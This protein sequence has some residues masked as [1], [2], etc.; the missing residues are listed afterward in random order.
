MT[1]NELPRRLLGAGARPGPDEE[2]PLI[3]ALMRPVAPAVL[4]LLLAYGADADQRRSDATPAIVVAA[5]REPV[6]DP[7][8]DRDERVP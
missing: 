5:R 7:P 1:T 8:R 4:R 6:E 2:A 3:T